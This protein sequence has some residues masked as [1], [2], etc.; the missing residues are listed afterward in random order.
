MPATIV[1]TMAMIEYEYE[2]WYS[3]CSE[4]DDSILT[5]FRFAN[6]AVFVDVAVRLLVR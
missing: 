4:M 3:S 5:L 6:S 2:S 1:M